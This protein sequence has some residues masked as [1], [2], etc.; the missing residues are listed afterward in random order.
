MKDKKTV[1]PRWAKQISFMF[2][3]AF[4]GIVFLFNMIDI[5]KLAVQGFGLTAIFTAAFT[6]LYVWFCCVIPAV[7]I[8]N[9]LNKKK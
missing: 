9:D 6:A 7:I 4:G 3:F 5:Y 2:V 1:V 8:K